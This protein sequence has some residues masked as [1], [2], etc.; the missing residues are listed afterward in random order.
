[1]KKNNY[2]ESLP[3]SYKGYSNPTYENTKTKSQYIESYDGT[4]LA[5]DITFPLSGEEIV[6]ENLPVILLA[7]RSNRRNLNDP[8]I[9]MG[10]D[11]V[12]FG[13]IFAV[14]ELRG[15]GVSYGVNDSFGSIEHS[16]DLISTTEW[17]ASQHWCTGKI[18]MLGCSNRAYIQLCASALYPDK[19]VALTPVVA[20]SD[21]YYQNYPNGVSAVPHIKLPNPDHMLSKTEYLETVVPVDADTDGQI[22]YEA[23]VNCHFNHNKNFFET[24][25]L[26]D[27]CRDSEHPDYDH[28][29]TNMTLPPFGKLDHFFHNASVK[30]HQYIGELESGTLGQLAHFIDFG[31]TVFLGPWTHFGALIGDSPFPNGSIDILESYCRWYDYVLKGIDNGFDKMPA[32]TYYMFNAQ[33]GHE[34]RFSESWPPENEVRT[35]L[36]LS[37]KASHTISS[38]HDGTLTLEPCNNVESITYQIRDDIIVFKNKEGLSNYDRS[39]LFWNGNMSEDVDQKGLT[40]TTAPLFSL[41]QNEMAGCVSVDLW[42]SSPARDVDFIVYLEEVLPDGTSHY[43]KDGVMRASHRTTGPNP[44]WQKMGA[45]WHTSMSSDVK[46]CLDEGLSQPTHIQFA[47]DPIAYHFSAQSRIRFTITCA[48]RA[49]YQH[50]MYENECPEITLYTGG[51]YASFISVP[52]LEESNQTYK[53]LATFDEKSFPATLYAFKENTYLY[54][55]SIWHKF[56]TPDAYT[57]TEHGVVFAEGNIHFCAVGAPISSPTMPDS[58]IPS[59][60]VHPF[61]TYRKQFVAN[62]PISSRD[63]N[64]FVP[65]RKNLYLDVFIKK[66]SESMPCIVYIHGYG[67]PYAYLPTQMLMMYE[68]GYA[69]AA[70]DVRNYPPNE[71][72]DYINDAKGAIRYLRANAAQFGINPDK[73]GMYGFSLGGNTT[74]MVAM[75]GDLPALE[76][77]VGGNLEYSSRVQ[78]AAAGFAWSDLLYMGKDIADEFQHSP[79]LQADRILMTDGEY[80]PSSEVIGFSGPGKGLKVLR[81]YMENGCTPSNSLFDSKLQQAASA[82][83]VNYANP[84]VP[85]IALFGGRGMD[86]INIAF[87][88]SLRTFEA[89]NKVDALTF[90]YGNTTGEYGEKRETQQALKFF[91]AS[92]LNEKRTHRILA[93]NTEQNIVVVDYVSKKLQKNPVLDNG[94]FLVH[95]DDFSPYLADIVSP[96][97]NTKNHCLDLLSLTGDNLISKYYDAHNTLILKIDLNP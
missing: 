6:T 74:L 92:Q 57:V 95:E 96:A 5:I 73:I 82:S 12:A 14:V 26:E 31:G 38:A 94:C 97:Y 62:V 81:E 16:K 44:A 20:V 23:Y 55:N 75:T 76:G 88:Q 70:I 84:S 78:A 90:L 15:C 45:T 17:L 79:Q 43:I 85:P 10:C 52:F 32:V 68:A 7:S 83:P 25:F 41:Y 22:A 80:S 18:G 9:K 86:T 56:K 27:M 53:G 69:I 93:F 37:P 63:Y 47:I 33:E 87:K 49:A 54:T 39:E 64:L 48:N 13:Y 4:K 29:K 91:F 60:P 40:F 89:L 59:A 19:I 58:R 65:G 51:Q 36:Y 77:D 46:R 67:S 11:L 28:K 50:N 2:K 42:V 66:H 71:F 35:P 24:L 30:Q 72:P 21:F 8:E 3:F 1:M 61:P 34:W